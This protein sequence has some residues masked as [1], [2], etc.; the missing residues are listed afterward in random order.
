MT[1]DALLHDII[2]HN[3]QQGWANRADFELGPG[4]DVSARMLIGQPGWSLYALDKAADRA[5]FVELD[6]S[7]DLA[8][9]AFVYSDQ[10]RLAR[11]LLTVPLGAL[12]ELAELFPEPKEVI[13]IF[14]IGRCGSTLIAN[15]LNAVPGVWSLSEPD[16]YSTLIMQNA[17]SAERLGFSDAQTVSLIRAC[18]RLLFRPPA[19]KGFDTFA[20][21]L[22]SQSLFHAD[23]FHQALPNSRFVFLYR[24]GV[25]WCNSFYQMIRKFGVP[26]LLTG[27]DRMMI[28]S[29]ATAASDPG[30]LHAH[31]DV[32]QTEVPT[33]LALAPAWVV[34]MAEYRR[35]LRGGVPFLALRYDEIN[36]ERVPS[37]QRL[38]AH[39]GLPE[40]HVQQ[41]LKAFEN[42]SQAGTKIARDV[43]SDRL[44]QAQLARLEAIIASCGEPEDADLRL[45][46]IYS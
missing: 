12:P 30:L 34:N 8:D 45:A 32:T 22:K 23:L 5:L 37:L 36:A 31:V 24:H 40:I 17:I 7:V 15:A 9:S 18:T 20:V 21:K 3:D 10:H 16:A 13:F 42:D 11:R 4:R 39:C 44:N 27:D 2:A 38:F 35:Q 46:D 6:P 41:A 19:G 26:A 1:S 25:T 29:A 14:N 43:Q 33:E 28:W